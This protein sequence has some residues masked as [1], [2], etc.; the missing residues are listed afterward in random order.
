MVPNVD[1]F[2]TSG[3]QTVTDSLGNYQIKVAENDSLSFYYN[4]KYTIKF[5]V[6]TIK[7]RDAFNISLQVKV[8]EKYKLLQGITV[9]SDSYLQDSIQ[10][11]INYANIFGSTGAQLHSSY[12]Q[13]GPAGLE[14]GSIISLF[15]FRKNKNRLSFQERLIT[16]E[17]DRYVDYRFSP[18][19]I[20]R[21][22]GLKGDNL[23]EY[24]KM[25]R[26]NY[27][28]LSKST[29]TQFYQYILNTSYVFKKEKGIP[30]SD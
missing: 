15:Q 21:I 18:K 11:R 12:E 30:I 3:A 7:S 26:P 24:I 4:N 20:T 19:T 14:I 10:N 28:M 23:K 13:G 6:K 27:Y 25:Y 16:E 29:L 5:P 8:V 9:F 1:V 2:N 17:Q 22:T